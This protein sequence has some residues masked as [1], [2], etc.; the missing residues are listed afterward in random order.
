MTGTVQ[1]RLHS[2]SYRASMAE[3]HSSQH[4]Q[5]PAATASWMQWVL[6]LA[7]IYN[8]IWGAFVIVFP[9]LPFQWAKMEPPRYPEIWQCVGMIVGV[10]GIGYIIAAFDP[11]RHWPVIF[12]GFL[13]KVLG[14]IGM[15][16][17]LWQ[18]KLPAVAALTCLTNDLIWWVPFGI[19]L[20][21]AYQAAHV[22]EEVARNL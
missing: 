17:A 9:L 16:N 21:C 5:Q 18:G 4:V 11:L 20:W 1:G 2:Q 22:K 13:G 8:L 7:G 6:W 10:Y 3:I 15:V 12:V 14:P 19:I